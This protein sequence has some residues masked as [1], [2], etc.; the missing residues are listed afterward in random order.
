[1]A[2]TPAD[3]TTLSHLLDEAL[4]LDPEQ[5]EPWLAALPANQAHLGDRLR[6][7]LA[8]QDRLTASG[9]LSTLPKLG[10]DE[11]TARAGERVGAYS[12]IREIGRGG[13][14]SVWLAARADGSFKREVALKL[15]RLAWG[16][17]LA[18]RM[19]REREIGALLEH[20][21]VAR[22]Y[23]AGVDERG[24]PFLALEY[25]DGQPIDAWC[26][27]Q[28]LSVRARLGLFLQVARA[29][30][31]AHGR[32]VVHRDLKPS[33]VLVTADGQAHLLDFGIA[34]LLHEAVPGELGLTQEQGRVLT[35]HYASPEQI[36]GEPITVASDVYSLGVLLYELLTGE[37]PI[38]PKRG[39]LGAVEEAILEGDAPLASGRVKDKATARALRGEVDAILAKA[40]QRDAGRRYATAD[41]M[42][43]DIERHLNGETVAA[44]PDSL[45][46]RMRK[47]VRRHWVGVSAAAAVAVA[48]LTGSGVAVVQ[49]QRA[50]QSAERERVVKDFV[51]DVFR[52]TGRVDPRNL[53]IRQ[54]SPQS[55]VESGAQLIQQRFAGQPDMQAELYGVIAEV[56]SDMGAHRMATDYMTRRIEALDL[57]HV[58]V[59]QRARALLMLAQALYDDQHV[60]DA[61]PRVRRVLELTPTDAAMRLEAL[62]LLARIQV[63]LGREEAAAATFASAET[64]LTD[65]QDGASAAR[66]WILASRARILWIHNR[67]DE[68]LPLFHQAV[69]GAIAAEGKLSR[70]AIAV[71][72]HAAGA[73]AQTS[74][75]D[76]AMSYFE[77]AI[78][79]LME[80][81]GAN[82]LRAAMA[83]AF[84][85]QRRFLVARQI[86]LQEAESVLEASRRQLS[87][88]QA[89]V[90]S[91]FGAQ[92]DCWQASLRAAV[93]DVASAVP[94][95]DKCAPV[96]HAALDAPRERLDL[97][98]SVGPAMLMAGR[99]TEAERWLLEKRDLRRQIGAGKHP[100]AAEDYYS[101][102]L[103]QSMQGSLR[104]AKAIL[105]EA[106]EFEGLVN[107]DGSTVQGRG[108]WL[109]ESE[110]AFHLDAGDLPGALQLLRRS[111]E[112]WDP[113][114]AG[115]TSA[116]LVQAVFLCASG[117]HASGYKALE[118][119]S[120][121]WEAS[122][123]YPADPRLARLRALTGSCALDAGDRAAA[124][125]YAAD[126]RAAFTAQP[127]VS[128]YFKAPLVKLERALGL[129]LPAV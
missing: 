49:A 14:G 125:R 21:H 129:R 109:I 105:A 127:G 98:L 32:L 101:L 114:R 72:L 3:L 107:P 103:N 52:V 50:A 89:P 16:A 25:I 40:M 45:T 12:L 28:G 108:K 110:A 34:K 20:P 23:D 58:D 70:T 62:V 60:G 43:L 82:E 18:E 83:A 10:A 59:K 74:Q 76:K 117:R 111:T 93:G 61:E 44:R 113:D 126:A 123:P 19:A 80:L 1:M 90:P 91:W 33:N 115:P 29:V 119:R 6:D 87:A 102:A 69:V 5:R 94:V 79:A 57:L 48:V 100:Y 46:Y 63:E 56:F 30:A 104:Q 106:P 27:A 78:A 81:G 4:A 77:P 17:G 13:M 84:F 86:S 8:E 53:A 99:H 121:A 128:P 22:M 54:S 24:R 68:A 120:K 2:L 96:V 112:D 39:T 75:V 122:A 36:A 65:K 97:A 35:P 38:A 51:A 11:A 95:F 71:R 92:I 67:L 85:A 15:P 7:M 73:L 41:A 37:L 64:L 88:S 66:S 47:E 118:R 55:L 9:P 31:Y 26:E 116:S 42:A 124:K